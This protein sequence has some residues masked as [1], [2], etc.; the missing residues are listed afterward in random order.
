MERIASS[1]GAGSMLHPLVIR[2]EAGDA[3][4]DPTPEEIPRVP[5]RGAAAHI[6]PLAEAAAPA[7]RSAPV[8]D[9]LGPGRVG[10]HPRLDCGGP[11]GVGPI[12]AGAEAPPPEGG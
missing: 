12:V 2:R 8:P 9:D 7:H 1:T 6:A 11:G 10:R 3:H 5:F 4:A